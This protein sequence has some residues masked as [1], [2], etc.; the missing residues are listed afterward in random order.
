MKVPKLSNVIY[1]Q[2][3]IVDDFYS[4]ILHTKLLRKLINGV[5]HFEQLV[6]VDLSRLDKNG[7]ING[8]Q[9]DK[10]DTQR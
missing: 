2:A 7:S 4:H 3:L 6:V 9:K 5:F 1:E 10:N 8:L